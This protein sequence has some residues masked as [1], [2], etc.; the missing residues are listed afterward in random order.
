[1]GEDA[2]FAVVPRQIALDAYTLQDC[3]N[4]ELRLQHVVPICFFMIYHTENLGLSPQQFQEAVQ[5][6]V[7]KFGFLV[8]K[9][10]PYEIPKLKI[11]SR[12]GLIR[13]WL[14][15]ANFAVVFVKEIR[16]TLLKDTSDLS[17]SSEIVPSLLQQPKYF[18]EAFKEWMKANDIRLMRSEDNLWTGKTGDVEKAKSLLGIRAIAMRHGL[19][20]FCFNVTAKFREDLDKINMRFASANKFGHKWD[21]N[22]NPLSLVVPKEDVEE[23]KSF[24]GQYSEIYD[25]WDP[26]YCESPLVSKNFILVYEANGDFEMKPYCMDCQIE[27]LKFGISPFAPNGKLDPDALALHQTKLVSPQVAITVT[28]RKHHIPIGQ[29]LW[30]LSH[31]GDEIQ[32]LTKLWVTGTF[33][34]SLRT[35]PQVFTSCPSH[36]RIIHLTPTPIDGFLSCSVPA[37]HMNYCATKCHCWH[38]GV[39]E[40]VWDGPKCPKCFVPTF[41][42]QGCNHITC[43]CGAHWCYKCGAGPF[44]D[45]SLTYY[46]MDKNRCWS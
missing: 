39:C 33:S 46:H 34:V 43:P 25:L 6:V 17:I 45:A 24:V 19:V 23:A 37:C 27:I 16:S 28:D 15:D 14:L 36:P 32:R 18:D 22:Y 7:E 29:L 35:N 10:T 12:I 13:V 20:P 41:K 42:N 3:F 21:L 11:M 40:Y 38:E 26:G 5:T 1:M 30:Q 44:R 2:F 8:L 9:S 31:S 4:F